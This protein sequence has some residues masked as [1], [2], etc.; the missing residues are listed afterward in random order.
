M[1]I[2]NKNKITNKKTIEDYFKNIMASYANILFF[3]QN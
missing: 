1:K 3:I 2:N